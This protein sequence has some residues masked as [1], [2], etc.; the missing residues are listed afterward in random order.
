MFKEL[1]GSTKK[2]LEGVR[3]V[4]EKLLLVLRSVIYSKAILINGSL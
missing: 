2:V 3:E 1:L 4:R